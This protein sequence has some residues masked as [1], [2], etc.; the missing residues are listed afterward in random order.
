MIL[1]RLTQN[2]RAQN[3]T[4]IVIELLIVV[5]GVFIGTQVANCRL[6]PSSAT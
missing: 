3:W 4:A 5:V 6:P 1:R 2:L